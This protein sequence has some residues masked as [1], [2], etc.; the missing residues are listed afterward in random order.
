MDDD[1]DIGMVQEITFADRS[2]ISYR[3]RFSYE[4][5]THL[6]DWLR[7]FQ[8][9]ERHEVSSDII[10]GVIREARKE[11]LPLHELTEPIV[12]RFLKRMNRA[13]YYDNVIAILNRILDRPPVDLSD[14]VQNQIKAMFAEIQ[15]PFMKLRGPKRKNMLSYSYILNKLFFMLG[16]PEHSN[17]FVLLKSPDKLRDQDVI[18]KRICLHMKAKYP[19][20]LWEFHPSIG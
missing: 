2:R 6:E 10:D 4:K 14:V 18:W 7:R 1:H 20:S 3:P 9:K 8:A 13:E 15:V 16:M 19:D 5:K 17:R 11:R 12:K